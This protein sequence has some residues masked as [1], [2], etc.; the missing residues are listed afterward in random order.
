VQN[1]KAAPIYNGAWIFADG[2]HRQLYNTQRFT[3]EP[4]LGVAIRINDKTAF[5]AGFA[6]YVIPPLLIQSTIA[7]GLPMA[8]YSQTT[9]VA[10]IL[11]GIPQAVLS[12][13][14]PTTNPLILPLEKS[15]GTYTNLG[16]APTFYDQAMH[17]GVNDRWNFSVQR[18]LPFQ[19]KVDGTFFM[20]FGHNLPYTLA[21]NMADPNICYTIKSQCDA[22]VANPFYQILTPQ[23][24][25]GTLRNQPNVTVSSLLTPY[26]QYGGISQALT[27]GILN[28]YKAIQLRAEKRLSAGLALLFA[29]NYNQERSS[30]FFNSIDQ[31]NHYFTYLDSN[32]PRHRASIAMSYDLPFGKGR[33]LLGNVHPILNGIIGGWQTSY[34]FMANSGN[35]LRFGQVTTN[36]QTPAVYRD[37]T[38]WFDTSLFSVAVPYTPR[39]NPY[40]YAG[41]TGPHYWNLDATLSKNFPIRERFNLEFRW[42][43]Y[44]SLNVFVPSDPNMTVTSAQFGRTTDQTNRGREMQYSL[45]LRF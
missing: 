30:N 12:N 6:R 21:L 36:G 29:Y 43:V 4:R 1:R 20:N 32:N 40:Q 42:E 41:V 37:R 33:P 23:T 3:L 14:F 15:L 31:Y 18:E 25:P 5:R 17:T 7:S 28:R 26:P 19:V 35:F 34:F 11:N 38:K 27:D 2:S 10:P 13:P 9:T 22:T 39:T 8:G 16:N 24:F 45:R 44:D